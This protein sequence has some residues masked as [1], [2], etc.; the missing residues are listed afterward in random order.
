MGLW[1]ELRAL[2]R[3]IALNLKRLWCRLAGH[4]VRDIVLKGDNKNGIVGHGPDVVPVKQC[5][6]CL[7]VSLRYSTEER[8]FVA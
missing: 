5:K 1:F 8:R 4:A 2:P 3:I 6:R 7:T